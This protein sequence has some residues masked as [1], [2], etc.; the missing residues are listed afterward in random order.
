MIHELHTPAHQHALIRKV[1]NFSLL[2]GLG[3]YREA[4]RVAM[5]E[6]N[7]LIHLTLWTGATFDVAMSWSFSKVNSGVE[8]VV[9]CVSICNNKMISISIYVKEMR[10]THTSLRKS[11]PIT[12]FA[13]AAN[14]PNFK[15]ILAVFALIAAH[16]A[17]AIL[18]AEISSRW[19][20]ARCNR[21]ATSTAT[22]ISC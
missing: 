12:G 13:M 5:K 8:F 6:L 18:P 17:A 1:P 11:S 10:C 15:L 22:S 7:S 21:T 9:Q 19:V 3:E 20:C 14:L 2:I 4:L 16:I